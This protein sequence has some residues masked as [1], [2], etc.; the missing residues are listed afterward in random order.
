[1]KRCNPGVELS[2]LKGLK[3]DIYSHIV[4]MLFAHE[5]DNSNGCNNLEYLKVFDKYNYCSK[6]CENTLKI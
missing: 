2:T 6:N 5:V 1:M 3:I 4:V